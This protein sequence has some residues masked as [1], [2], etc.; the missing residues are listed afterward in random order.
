MQ[1]GAV[2]NPDERGAYEGP[3]AS[4]E[5][6]RVR[7]RAQVTGR[8]SENDALSE[9]AARAL[10]AKARLPG[11]ALPSRLTALATACRRTTS[12]ATREQL[13]H[14]L[15]PYLAGTE[16]GVWR[17]ERIGWDRYY[18]SF[19]GLEAARPLSKCLVLKAPAAD[20]EKG[21]FYCPFEYNLMQLVAHHDARAILSEYFLVG[22]ASWSPTDYAALA[23]CAGLSDDPIF[24]GVANPADMA[25]YR[26]LDPVIRPIPLMASDWIDP[27]DYTARTV[28]QRDIDIL[29]VANWSRF[30]RHWLLFE[31]LS[32]MPLDLRVVLVGRNAP[33]RSESDIRDEAAAFGVRQAVEY[34][35]NIPIDRVMALQ[36]DARISLI[37]SHRE[38]SCVAVPESLFAGTPVGMMEDGHVG[39]KSYINSRTGILLR[40]P[41]LARQL[42]AFLERSDSFAPR[43][44]AD[45]NISCFRSAERLNDILR[46]HS[47][48]AGLPWTGD[49]VPF[50]RRYVPVYANPA[51]EVCL[52][53]A[54]E[55]LERRYGV[56]LEKFVYRP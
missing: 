6:L 54:V 2:G 13:H 1:L 43:E 32:E 51:D 11:L 4:L 34:Y 16:S 39:S 47:R 15:A 49:A 3:P 28:D 33:G 23:N 26:V 31:A 25:A 40:R 50:C 7:A 56:V 29:M 9:G 8:L 21:V 53:P 48:S 27:R 24:V 20:G 42:S 36:A 55:A 46:N 10:I 52:I 30:K 14:L 45:K 17:K 41:G 38:G 35:T 5:A 37:L 44:W 19:G 22:E 12:G 18:G